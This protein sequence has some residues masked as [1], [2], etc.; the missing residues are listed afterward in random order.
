MRHCP[1]VKYCFQT[2]NDMVIRYTH[3]NWLSEVY[4][5]LMNCHQIALL[6][7]ASLSSFLTFDDM[8]I[9]CT[10]LNQLSEV[11]QYLMDCQQVSLLETWIVR[12]K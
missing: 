8:V 9:R 10:H 7:L 11:H 12:M 3:L 4:Q 5:Y 6:D 1:C 2:F